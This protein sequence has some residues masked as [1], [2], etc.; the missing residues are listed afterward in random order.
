MVTQLRAWSRLVHPTPR[1]GSSVLR[2]V[3]LGALV[4]SAFQLHLRASRLEARERSLRQRTDA[5]A[6]LSRS[7][8]DGESSQVAVSAER[9]RAAAS[10]DHEVLRAGFEVTRPAIAIRTTDR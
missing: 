7:A 6:Y 1:S 3:V 10:E 8:G 4:F 2:I 9:K 5:S